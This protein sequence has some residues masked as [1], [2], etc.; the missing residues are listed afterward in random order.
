MLWKASETF[1]IFRKIEVKI[2]VKFKTVGSPPTLA[3]RVL[4]ETLWNPA[5]F[6]CWEIEAAQGWD[7]RVSVAAAIVANCRRLGGSLA[8]GLQP[9]QKTRGFPPLARRHF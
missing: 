2:K 3:Q 6:C 5:F 1:S 4:N 9:A 7:G 8:A